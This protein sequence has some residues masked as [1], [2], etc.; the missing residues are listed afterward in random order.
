MPS[1]SDNTVAVLAV[2]LALAIATSILF[3]WRARA[4]ARELRRLRAQSSVVERAVSDGVIWCDASWSATNWNDAAAR[5][6]GG[7]LAKGAPV[8]SLLTEGG[9]P[10]HEALTRFAA[11]ASPETALGTD[12]RV[13]AADGRTPVVVAVRRLPSG[14][15]FVLAARDASAMAALDDERARIRR[16]EAVGQ[17]ARGV[18]HDFNDLL[19][20]IAGRSEM[21]LRDVR[22]GMPGRGDLEEVR[23]AVQRASALAR[24]L[25]GLGQQRALNPRPISLDEFLRS[26]Q[27]TLPGTRGGAPVELVLRSDAGRVNADPA[28]LSS[29]VVGVVQH[30]VDLPLPDTAV[31]VR[32]ERRRNTAPHGTDATAAGDFAVIEIAGGRGATESPAPG[33][34]FAAYPAIAEAN[35]EASLELASAYA[36]A[37]EGGGTLELH[38]VAGTSIRIR[39]TL[40]QVAEDAEVPRAGRLIS[41]GEP[42]RP[43]VLVAEDEESVRL[44]V[45]VVL[46]KQGYRVLQAANGVEAMRLLDDPGITVDVLL[47]DVMMPQMGGRELAERMLAVQPDLR[48]VFMSGY[49]A[50]R[51]LLTGVA[52]RHAPLLQKPFTLEEM[53]R[54][55]RESIDESARV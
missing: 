4:G 55:V 8:G 54:V 24:R 21:A 12:L 20:I 3:L 1:F 29:I 31:A 7:A 38:S 36:F 42:R 14:S 17:L 46:E 6:F 35:G 33:A 53:V 32:T 13:L 43:T 16:M 34:S 49:V 9:H 37:R 28:R 40:P 47:T 45:R 39:L 27:P 41:N 18:A 48:V 19:T 52:E 25:L 30:V 2:A 5:Q 51:A 10:V 11:T 23:L 50:N 26:V 44:F 22:P 15:G